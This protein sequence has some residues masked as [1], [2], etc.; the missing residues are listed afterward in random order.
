M[1]AHRGQLDK[2]G[3]PYIEHP[4]HVAASVYGDAAKA[5]AW[6]HDVVED[7]DATVE[8]LRA[9]G[10][11]EDVLEAVALL[12]HERGTPYLEYVRRV[13]E[14]PIARVV[15]LADLRHNS[16]LSRLP[17]VGKEDL[18]RMKRYRRAIRILEE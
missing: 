14:N 2:A 8:D 18:R 13:K 9:A 3:R 12:T 7:T 15:K 17:E 6:L 10:I 11:S 16:D 4:E 5:A 1:A